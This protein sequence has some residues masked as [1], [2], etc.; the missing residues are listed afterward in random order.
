MK[1]INVAFASDNNYAQHMAVSVASL[2]RN[3]TSDCFLHIYILFEDLTDTHKNNLKKLSE[4]RKSTQID[5]IKLSLDDFKDYPL[6]TQWHSIATYFR[7]KL[8]SLLPDITHIMYL[9]SDIIVCDDISDVWDSFV[10]QSA[11]I[12]AVEEP[13]PLYAHRLQSLGM[14]SESPYFNG[15]VLLLNLYKMRQKNFEEEARSYIEKYNQSIQFQDQD[16]LNA[17]SED[18]WKPLPLRW[19]SFFFVLEGIYRGKYKS[20]SNADIQIAKSLPAIIHYNQHPKPW[21]EGCIDPRRY[22]Y[23]E[24]LEYTPYKGFKV[25]Q[26]KSYVPILKEYFRRLILQINVYLP[27]LYRALRFTKRALVKLYG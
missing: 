18:D 15:G 7:L 1:T 3:A 22:A 25:N 11:M 16:V 19:N 8:P 27:S 23:F 21:A 2:M 12:G 9:D 26:S 20:Y 6:H 14:K 24:Y 17:L 5:F 10:S 4:I 13:R